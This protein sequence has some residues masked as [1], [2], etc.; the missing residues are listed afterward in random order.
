MKFSMARR[1][2]TF[3]LWP[4]A[5][6]LAGLAFVS[7]QFTRPAQR[8]RAA[9]SFSAAQPAQ[10]ATVRFIAFGD[11]GTGDADQYALAKQMTA[12]QTAHPFDTVLLLGD[13]IYPDGNPADL[14]AK[15]E[16]PYAELLQRGIRFQA[17]LGNHDVKKG[18]AA[19]IGYPNFNMGGQA[20][21]SFVKGTNADGKPLAE[22]FALDSNAMDAA[23]LNWFEGALKVSQAEWKLVFFHHPLYS[24]ATTHGSDAALRAKLEPLFVRYGIVAAFSGHDHTYERTKPMQGVQYFVSGAGSGKL[25]RGDLNRKSQ[26][27]AAGNDENG[28]FLY[29]ELT[30]AELNFQAVDVTGKVFDAGR[31]L[32]KLAP[33]P[34]AAPALALNTPVVLP[35]SLPEPATTRGVT[36]T[37]NVES[38]A[39]PVTAVSKPEKAKADKA[40]KASKPVNEESN[41]QPKLSA[42]AAQTIALQQVPGTVESSELKR[43]DGQMIYAVKIRNG[44]DAAEVRINAEDGT[45][46][47]VKR[48]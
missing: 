32:P 20:Y 37:T 14:P 19:Q 11:M 46:V 7:Y 35:N 39:P 21:Y 10:S 44:K 13:N 15:F 16:K 42:D 18:R 22:F 23:Q 26:F 25:R 29:V 1:R 9:A 8:A 31:L 28:S 2:F 47:R 33:A 36:K 24:S 4:L 38:A 48:K 40:P 30:Q 45:V 27:F 17:S 41:G 6:V 12:W 3:H 43:K 5:L 34:A